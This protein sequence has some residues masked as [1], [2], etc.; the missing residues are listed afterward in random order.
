[1]AET[2]SPLR[3]GF[4]VKVLGDPEVKSN[5]SRRWKNN[6]HLRVSLRYLS[7]LF[8]YLQKHQITMYRMSSDL[9]PY[10]THPDLPQFH[11]MVEECGDELSRIGKRARKQHIRLSFHPSQFIVLNSEN[12][13]LVRK[14]TWDLES[15]AEMLDRMGTGEE[16]VLVVHVGGTY[17]DRRA[18]LERWVR[19]WERLPERVRQRLVLE[20]DDIRYSA[21]DVIWIHERTGVRMVFDYQHLWC[22]NPEGMSVRDAIEPMLRSW[23]GSA[24]PKIHFSSPRTEMRE[25]KRKNKKTGK[26]E[27]RPVAPIWTGHAD[28]I[29]PFEF[30]TFM[31]TCA[32]LEFDVMLEAKSK[33]LALIRLRRDLVRYAPDVAQRFGLRADDSARLEREEKEL[34]D[35]EKAA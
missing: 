11:K 6:P 7:G 5:D 24:R 20:N 9:A 22:F 33:D 19:T 28:F 8:D 27:V 21:A 25:A 3:L 34:M 35:S 15:Q 31:R 2:A 32:D 30:C 13:E 12:P 16:A 17:G 4:P 23:N 14:S 29:N 1:M 18:G 10:C 26:Q